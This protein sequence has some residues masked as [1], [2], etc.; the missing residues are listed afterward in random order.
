MI[1]G[2]CFCGAISYKIDGSLVKARACHCSRCRKL[3]SSASSAYAELAEGS[4][5]SWATGEEQLTQYLNKQGLGIAFCRVCGSS[6]CIV[7]NGNVQ[8]VTLGSVNGDPGTQIE[9]HIFVESKSPWD[10]IGGNVPQFKE[11]PNTPLERKR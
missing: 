7:H 4:K 3:F 8:G 9:M 6:L 1:T 10:H 2:E 11:W 5:F